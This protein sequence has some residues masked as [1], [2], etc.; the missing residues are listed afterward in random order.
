MR[1]INLT[2]ELKARWLERLATGRKARERL[3]NHNGGMCCL[4]HLCDLI[5]PGSWAGSDAAP[6]FRDWIW[7]R[8]GQT[9]PPFDLMGKWG[10]VDFVPLARANDAQVGFPIDLIEALEPVE[11]ES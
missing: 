10:K 11:S 6:D 2:P 3:R 8:G 5:A 9:F 4:G 7:G 1:E